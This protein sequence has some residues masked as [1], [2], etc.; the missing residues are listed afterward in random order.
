MGYQTPYAPTRSELSSCIQCGLCLPHCPTFRLT[1]K[2]TDSP[3]GR[4]SAMTAVLDGVIDMDDVFEET[5]SFCLGCRACEPVCPSMVPYGRTLEGARA[6][7]FA[8]KGGAARRLR[9]WILETW[10][11]SRGIIGMIT[12][13]TALAQRTGLARIAPRRLRRGL[14]GLRRVK[15]ITPS[16]LGKTFEPDQDPLATVGFLI[17]CIMGPWFPEVHQAS[18][19][20]LVRGGYRVVVPATQTCCG[21]LAAHDGA[22]DGARRLATRNAAAFGEVDYV[23]ADAAG[24]SAH[25]KDYRHWVPDR[26]LGPRWQVRDIT[27]LIAEAIKDG[28]LPQLGEKRGTV[29]L[30]HPCHLRNAQ[31]ITDQPK[32]ILA[33]AGYDAVDIDPQCCGAAGFY[34]MLRPD[35]SA[36]FGKDKVADIQ[37]SGAQVVASA[38]P[39]C[40]MQLRSHLG[41]G[42]QVLHP[43]ELYE[44][45][46]S[47]QAAT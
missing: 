35:T 46:L 24:C 30:Q 29:A 25:L 37:R 34:S 43:V 5:I 21:A 7:I 41:D 38:N 18:I 36:R 14:E 15:W 4:L 10:L 27:E 33:A 44:Q 23:V 26:D 12:W 45:A 3:R 13:A 47:E 39:G 6:E 2:E 31:R 22:A 8:Q 9:A 16:L 17:G 40:E 19:S 11:G 1:G 42:Y 32:A 20:L 28:R